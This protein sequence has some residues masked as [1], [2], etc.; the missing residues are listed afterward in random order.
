M[1]NSASRPIPAIRVGERI[2]E[3]KAGCSLIQDAYRTTVTLV[4]NYDTR[5]KAVTFGSYGQQ[6]EINSHY[7]YR[8]SG[9]FGEY[10]EETFTIDTE[11]DVTG[12]DIIVTMIN[13]REVIGTVQ[14]RK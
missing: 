12:F 1:K 4:Y 8:V 2:V 3:V 7:R 10:F 13:G 9:D 5:M 6:T 11:Q 14:E